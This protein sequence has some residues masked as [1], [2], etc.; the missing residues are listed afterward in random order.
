MIAKL[1]APIKSVHGKLTPGFYAR[2]LNGKQIIQRCPRRVKAP[3]EAQLEARRRFV[4]K[5]RK[6]KKQ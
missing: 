1:M 3:T 2:M 6:V 5:Y 4:E